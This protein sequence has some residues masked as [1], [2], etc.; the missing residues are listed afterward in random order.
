MAAKADNGILRNSVAKRRINATK[1]NAW[2]KFAD[3]LLPLLF[4]FTELLAITVTTF[5]PPK[6]PLIT[7]AKPKA[8]MSLFMLERLFRGSNLSTAFILNRLSILAINVIEITAP[9]NS[10]CVTFP[11]SGKAKL[12]RISFGNAISEFLFIG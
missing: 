7:V 9:I 3:R 1:N 6:K 8:L 10:I 12:D 11:K 4:T 5:S 2:K